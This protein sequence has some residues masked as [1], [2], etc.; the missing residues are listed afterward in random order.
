MTDSQ[1]PRDFASLNLENARLHGE[2]ARAQ[3]GRVS[4]PLALI[5]A[6][7]VG[8]GIAAMTFLP[9]APP[10][11]LRAE[12]CRGVGDGEM[13]QYNSMR[14]FIIGIETNAAARGQEAVS[15]AIQDGEIVESVVL[16]EKVF[17]AGAITNTRTEEICNSLTIEQM[18][19]AT[20]RGPSNEVAAPPA[21]VMG[22]GGPL[23]DK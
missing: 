6:A 12:Y 4:G 9:G 1:K 2:L 18:V 23:L 20:L 13:R 22:G 16:S 17:T 11:D 21:P 14:N 15:V 8:G 19:Q 3:K 7:F 5:V 10:A